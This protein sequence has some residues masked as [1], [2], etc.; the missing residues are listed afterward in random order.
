MCDPLLLH[1]CRVH[2]VQVMQA[3]A[4]LRD[5][6]WAVIDA[7]GT[8]DDIHKQV[9][10]ASVTV[11]QIRSCLP[12]THVLLSVVIRHSPLKARGPRQ[13]VLM[14]TGGKRL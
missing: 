8:I 3:F 9:G 14:W 5:E 6:R 10:G 2:R 1:L 12:S 7:S 11:A 13:T 4:A